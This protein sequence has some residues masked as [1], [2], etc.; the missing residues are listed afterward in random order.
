MKIGILSDTHDK[1][2]RTIT[3]VEKLA[4]AGAEALIHCGD[5]TGPEIIY[6]CEGLPTYYV[7][8]N[9]EWDFVGLR[10]AM[11][12]AGGTC[13]EW[14]GVIELAAKTIAVT[15]GHLNGEIRKLREQ[16]PDYFLFG[17][18]HIAE[19]RREGRIRLI[20]PGALHRAAEFSVAVLDLKTDELTFLAIER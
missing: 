4:A 14:G 7:F 9:N 17:H 8:G 20:N 10:R 13:L 12:D 3:A 15:H 1:L 5:L 6:A 2:G 19:D 18:S 11:R 16:Q